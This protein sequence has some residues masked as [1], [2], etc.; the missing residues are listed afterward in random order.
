MAEAAHHGVG[1]TMVMRPGDRPD[2][3]I[4]A[5]ADEINADLIVM[6]QQGLRGLTRMMVGDATLR[7]IGSATCS[8]P[9]RGVDAM[10]R[11]SPGCS[12]YG[13]QQHGGRGR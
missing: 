7:V 13:P 2:V 10:E 1:V 12:R 5:A 9:L 8:S 11:P 6:G 4:V 3:E